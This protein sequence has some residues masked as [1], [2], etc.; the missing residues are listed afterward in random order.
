MNV[1]FLS[2]SWTWKR[3]LLV[4]QM[5]EVLKKSGTKSFYISSVRHKWSALNVLNR[6]SQKTAK[7]QRET[8]GVG[9]GQRAHSNGPRPY[10]SS[11]Y[12]VSIHGI[13][14]ITDCLL[15]RFG[16]NLTKG[17]K[18]GVLSF[19]F[20]FDRFL[21]GDSRFWWS[22]S[23]RTAWAGRLRELCFFIS[24]CSWRTGSRWLC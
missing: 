3:C 24:R 10:V 22:P 11:L 4:Y 23:L 18:V 17:M 20:C 13:D 5:W 2:Q 19:L 6:N 21:G 8:D 1:M 15:Y 7:T 9:K 14:I 12:F 16:M